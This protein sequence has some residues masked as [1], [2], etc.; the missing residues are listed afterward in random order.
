M[1]KDE[2]VPHVP[3]RTVKQPTRPFRRASRY[4]GLFPIAMPWDN[5]APLTSGELQLAVKLAFGDAGPPDGY[6]IVAAGRTLGSDPPVARS[7]LSE[8]EAVGAT[9][10]L[11]SPPDLAAIDD[12]L[13]IIKAGPPRE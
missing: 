13:A 11:E 3:D 5:G 9:W 4:Q 8:Y 7:E 1:T 6:E 10:W 2:Y 12:A